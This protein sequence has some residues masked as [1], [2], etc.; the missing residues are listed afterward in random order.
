MSALGI[1]VV[2]LGW[3]GR[4]IVPL[5]K[6]SSKLRVVMGVDPAPEAAA[7]SAA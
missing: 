1:A 4:I 7:T 6:T 2:G 5:A 3:W